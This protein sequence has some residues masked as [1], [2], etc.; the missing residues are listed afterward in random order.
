MSGTGLSLFVTGLTLNCLN[1]ICQIYFT[2]LYGDLEADYINSIELCKRVNRLSVPEAILQAFISALFLFNGYW[3]VFLLNV[4]V[5]AYNASKV[6]KK[7]H[8]LDATDI[9]RKLGRC[10]IE[11]FLKLGFYLLIFF[12][13]FYRMVTALLEND[14]NLIS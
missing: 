8:L 6:Y 4:P 9:F 11:C 2:I 12:F 7:T 14:A 10:K 3:F 5:L 1:S 13:Y